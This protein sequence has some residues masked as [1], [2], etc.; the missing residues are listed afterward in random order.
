MGEGYEIKDCDL[1]NNRNGYSFKKMYIDG[2][3]QF[4]EFYEEVHAGK[5]LCA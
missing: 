3:C 5:A 1:V 2:T 4:D